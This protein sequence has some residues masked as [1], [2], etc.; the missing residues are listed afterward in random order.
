[1]KKILI[2]TVFLILPLGSAFAFPGFI[3]VFADTEGLSTYLTDNGS[4]VQVY[5]VH[6]VTSGASGSQFMV[7]QGNGA[8]MTY[9]G[10]TSPFP[11]VLGNS[12]TGIAIAYGVC[13]YPPIHLLTI[14][15][16]GCNS[17][18]CSI[19]E[20]VPD[21]AVTPPEILVADCEDPPNLVAAGGSFAWVNYHSSCAIAAE[22]TSWGQIKSLYH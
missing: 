7:V 2:L 9:L 18:L 17:P 19:V 8:C 5:I 12:Q 11:T 15:Y 21:P 6:V 20:T 13:L 3:G 10:E 14:N 4:L 16:M 22:A 1:M